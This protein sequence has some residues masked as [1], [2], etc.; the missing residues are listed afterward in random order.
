MGLGHT[1]GICVNE[2][3]ELLELNRV[4]SNIELTVFDSTENVILVHSDTADMIE[5]KT[6]PVKAA[7][8]FR[9]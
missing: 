3:L 9:A 7:E 5:L 1:S 4:G 8:S 6:T 2:C